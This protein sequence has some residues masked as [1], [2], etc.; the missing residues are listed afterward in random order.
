MEKGLTR[1]AGLKYCRG[2]EK[3]QLK[4]VIQKHTMKMEETLEE[5]IRE[6]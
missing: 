1:F 2:I 6:G 5:S 3:E 4:C